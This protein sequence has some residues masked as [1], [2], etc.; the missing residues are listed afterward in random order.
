MRL[1]LVIFLLFL[2]G[3]SAY[4]K[5]TEVQMP[6]KYFTDDKKFLVTIFKKD[7][8]IIKASDNSILYTYENKYGFGKNVLFDNDNI[9]YTTI[10]GTIQSRKIQTG[11]LNWFLEH[12]HF[13]Q[14]DSPQI[15]FYKNISKYMFIEIKK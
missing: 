12:S 1:Y 8:T 13:N 6:I 7:L 9:Y 2:H 11:K 5:A 3:F 15:Y 4:G 14:K 10:D